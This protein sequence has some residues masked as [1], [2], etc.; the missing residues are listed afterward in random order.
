MMGLN[1]WLRIFRGSIQE[2]NIRSDFTQYT[3]NDIDVRANKIERHFEDISP[4]DA[5]VVAEVMCE[6]LTEGGFSMRS[7]A[8]EIMA[9]TNL[10]EERT[11]ELVNTESTA[12]SNLRR[13]QSYTEHRGSSD[14]VYQWSGPEDHRTTKICSGIKGDIESRGGA[15]SLDQLRSIIREHA[16]QHEDGTPDRADEFVPH[17]ECR[18]VLVRHVR[19]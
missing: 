6:R 19:T 9:R 14:Y 16:K 15:V 5:Q 8:D 3:W 1:E 17:R 18:H 7:I 13:V 2:E 12:M 10:R 4:T 11:F